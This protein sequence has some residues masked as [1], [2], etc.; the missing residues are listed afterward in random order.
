MVAD[1]AECGIEVSVNNKVP[2]FNY[3]EL[4]RRIDDY[5]RVNSET[6]IE[7]FKKIRKM[8]NCDVFT[9]KEDVVGS[10]KVETRE[11]RPTSSGS[12]LPFGTTCSRSWSRIPPTSWN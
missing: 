4:A 8:R 2:N 5:Y 6:P 12:P 1:E 11:G 10:I 9:L 3:T 7:G